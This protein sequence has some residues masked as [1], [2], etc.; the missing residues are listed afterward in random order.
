MS[1]I[2]GCSPPPSPHPPDR[3]DLNKNGFKKW[4]SRVLV[5]PPSPTSYLESDS[6]Y[7]PHNMADVAKLNKTLLLP[8]KRGGGVS[9]G[10]NMHNMEFLDIF[11]IFND[12]NTVKKNW[13]FGRGRVPSRL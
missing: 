4:F 5:S 1:A 11:G 13:E 6:P 9:T 12:L 2:F 10:D 7:H 8:Q 3:C